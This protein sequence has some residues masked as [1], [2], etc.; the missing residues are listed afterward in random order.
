VLR[1][2][3]QET[4][5]RFR[6]DE[7]LLNAPWPEHLLD[8]PVSAI[9]TIPVETLPETATLADAFQL[10]AERRRGNLP[11]VDAEGKLTGILTRTDLYRVVADG[12]PLTNL[13]TELATRQI[14]TL[15]PDQSLREAL[16]VLRRKRVKHA[17][18]IDT[19]GKPVGMLSYMDIALASVR[20]DKHD[21]ST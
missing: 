13:A 20:M 6:P 3:F 14:T 21:T 4:S 1:Q 10:V 17:P 8:S 16:T 11:L 7:E 19:A 2:A 9:M 18:V 15:R 12:R 5:F